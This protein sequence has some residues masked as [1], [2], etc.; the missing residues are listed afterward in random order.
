MVT[1]L[2]ANVML[3]SVAG[4]MLVLVVLLLPIAL[5]EAAVLARMLMLKYGRAFN[6]SLSAN[7]R[8]TLVGLPLGYLCALVGVIPAGMFALLLPK[9]VSSPIGCVLFHM[10]STGGAPPSRYDDLGFCLGT[11]ILMVPYFF[12]TLREERR[13]ILNAEKDL[14]PVLVRRAVFRMNAVTYAM[15]AIPLLY[16]LSKT[17]IWLA[18][19][20]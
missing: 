8:S 20:K 4:H 10:I 1:M 11:L 14:D 3:P 12:L 18:S 16:E 17:V 15:L 9:N 13:S 5:I 7:S 6:L 19:R 2:I